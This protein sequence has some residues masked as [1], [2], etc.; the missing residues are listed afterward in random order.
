MEES[1]RDMLKEREE[2]GHQLKVLEAI[3]SIVERTP[4]ATTLEDAERQIGRPWLDLVVEESGLT[5]AEVEQAVE[6]LS[7]EDAG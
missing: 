6:K 2:T 3:S 1:L 7:A 4:G 5:A